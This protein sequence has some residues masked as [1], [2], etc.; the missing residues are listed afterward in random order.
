MQFG[1]ACWS[2]FTPFSVICVRRMS[3]VSS[4]ANPSMCS[5]ASVTCVPAR[6]KC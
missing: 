4:W 1:I 3:K 6:H 2:F 5:K